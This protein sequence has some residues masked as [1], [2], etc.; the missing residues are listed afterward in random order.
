MWAIVVAAAAA[1]S[2]SNHQTSLECQFSKML[3]L[4]LHVP[5]LA[6]SSSTTFVQAPDK[7]LS[8]PFEMFALIDPGLL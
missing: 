1:E 3:L 5:V 7:E 2:S 8:V 6:A 4:S